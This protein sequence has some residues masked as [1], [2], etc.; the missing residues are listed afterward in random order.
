MNVAEIIQMVSMSED[1]FDEGT[2]DSQ[3]MGMIE[4]F[5]NEAG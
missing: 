5:V 3:S 4:D 2:F 1:E